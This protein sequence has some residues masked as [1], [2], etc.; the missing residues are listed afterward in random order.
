MAKTRVFTNPGTG[1]QTGVYHVVSRFVDRRKVFGDEEREVFR[2]MMGAF[3][4]FHQVEILTFCLMGNHFHLL[5]RVPERPAEF[6][7]PLEQMMGMMDRAVG[8]ERMKVLR[9]QLIYGMESSLA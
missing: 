6:D 9:S 7:V 1:A 8:P 5:I 3:A 2:A 4:A